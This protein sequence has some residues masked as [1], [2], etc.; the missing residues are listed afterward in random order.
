MTSRE[1]KDNYGIDVSNPIQVSGIGEGYAYLDRI[2]TLE[3]DGI[4]YERKGSTSTSS[5]KV[6]RY[7]IE[8]NAM[9]DIYSIRDGFGDEIS[10]FYICPYFKSNSTIAP[11]GFKYQTASSIRTEGEKSPSNPTI[12]SYMDELNSKSDEEIM[13]LTKKVAKDRGLQIPKDF[14]IE[15]FLDFVENNPNPRASKSSQ[16]QSEGCFIATATLG[17][18]DD[19]LVL[20]LRKFRDNW[21]LKK[22]WGGRFV[23]MYY[24]Y[25]AIASKYIY[26]SPLLKKIS[27]YLIIYPLYFCSKV[28][29]RFT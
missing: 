3:G 16:S 24:K 10:T 29:Q 19:P 13:E 4:F 2:V 1:H 12:D 9:V 23:D 22:T 21:I 27:L 28:I 6:K 20:E 17:N 5:I 11:K 8:I 26:S 7:G 18:Y 25:G 14:D 15:E